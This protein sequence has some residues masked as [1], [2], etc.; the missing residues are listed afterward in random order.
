MVSVFAVLRRRAGTAAA[1]TGALALFF[2]AG[3][4]YAAEARGY[5]VMMGLCGITFYAWTEAAAGRRRGLYVPLLGAALAASVWNHYFGVLVFVPIAVGEAVRVLQRHRFDV[6]MAAAIAGAVILALPLYPLMAVAA[7]Q[8]SSFWAGRATA[9]ALP[10]IYRF[11]LAPMLEPAFLTTIAVVVVFAGIAAI[12]RRSMPGEARRVPAHEAAALAA[13]VAMPIF[14][15]VLAW[16][17][18]GVLVPRYL[19]S[20]IVPIGIALPLMLWRANTRRT[21][22]EA[23]ACALLVLLV[24]A[25]FVR[26]PPAFRDPVADRPVL[27]NSLKTPVPTVV[28]SSLQ[29]LQLVVLHAARVEGEDGVPRR[30]A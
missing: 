13:G 12:W 22:A 17:I 26:D 18:A 24:A 29:Y 6:P 3:F 25:G 19:L 9:P 8:R 23:L 21:P 7:A 5:G 16:A 15:L 1:V 14:G 28:S 30:P 2:T 20:A 4:R 10:D 27:L 11:L